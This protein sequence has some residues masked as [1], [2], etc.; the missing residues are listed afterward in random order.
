MNNLR[1]LPRQDKNLAP[2]DTW[3]EMVRMNCPI[4]N[5]KGWCMINGSQS[6]VICMRKPDAS[7]P[8]KINGTV[9]SLNSKGFSIPKEHFNALEEEERQP[10]HIQHKIHQ[11]LI[12]LFGLTDED[13]KHLM[14]VRK[15]SEK[16]IQLRGYFSTSIEN[17]RKQVTPQGTTIWEDVLELNGL[18][19]DSWKGVAGFSFDEKHKQVVFKAE[20][21]IAIPCRNAKG[22]IVDFQVRIDP[23]KIKFKAKDVSDDKYHVH[24]KNIDGKCF[25]TVRLKDDWDTIIFQGFANPNLP[26]SFNGLDLTFKI[27]QSAKYKFVSSNGEKNGTSARSVPHFAFADSILEQAQ[28]DEYGNSLVNLIELLPK[29][30]AYITEGFLKGDIIAGFMD[31]KDFGK[32]AQLVICIAGV[33]VWRKA[34]YAFKQEKLEKVI[35]MFDTDFVDNDTVYEAMGDMIDLFI[36][37]GYPTYILTWEVGKGF[38]DCLLSD[39][40][41]EQK[42]VLLRKYIN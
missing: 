17:L 19:R 7:K 15:L 8:Q 9:Y 21:G 42:N 23:K 16:Q 41:E 1:K 2:K 24:F 25:V 34:F 26:V 35:C 40:P 10:D 27:S 22:Q 3:Y 39:A 14:E 11:I 5:H 6:E 32:G 13:K 38:D 29:K 20:D 28:F 12:N 4:C 30:N 18:P 36:T 33:N 37:S 31:T